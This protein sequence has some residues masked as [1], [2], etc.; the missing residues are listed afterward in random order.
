MLNAIG[1]HFQVPRRDICFFDDN[2]LNALDAHL[3]GFRSHW[4][5]WGYHAPEHFGIAKAAG[6][7]AAELTDLIHLGVEV[8]A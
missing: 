3:A 1:K 6:L 2:V 8:T 7:F 5:V 4:A